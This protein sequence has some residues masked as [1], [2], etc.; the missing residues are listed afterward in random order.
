TVTLRDLNGNPIVS[1]RRYLIESFAFPTQFIGSQIWSGGSSVLRR[2]AILQFD[3]GEPI[4]F[5]QSGDH[6]RLLTN[7]VYVDVPD[8]G[9]EFPLY[10]SEDGTYPGVQLDTDEGAFSRWLVT[11]PSDPD[12][13]AGNYY[14]F[15]NDHSGKFMSARDS[16]GWLYVE[17]SSI[18]PRTL[19]RFRPL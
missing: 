14:A 8:L 5:E 7:R 2:W 11:Q 4:R 19:W 3:S 1:G 17:K 10:L 6:V 9:I 16:L 15:K 12:L 18:E 13:V